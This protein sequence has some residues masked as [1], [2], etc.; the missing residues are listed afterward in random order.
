MR[1]Y[2]PSFYGDI[3]LETQEKND[4][5][6][7]V[8]TDLS[9]AEEAIVKKLLEKFIIN[10]SGV[11]ENKSF[12]LE[13]PLATAHKYLKGIMKKKGPQITAVSV[14]GTSDTNLQLKE[15]STIDEAIETGSEEAVTTSVPKRGC[16]MPVFN[17]SVERHIR[18]TAVLLRFLTDRQKSDFEREHAFVTFGGSSRDRYLVSH[19]HS[20]MASNKGIVFNLD[21]NRSV[22]VEQSILPPAEELLA[23]LATLQCREP[24][25]IEGLKE[26][27]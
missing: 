8:T 24:E 27:N 17:P 6:I 1:I 4:N 11:L 22:C 14:I 3:K 23:I 9:P 5:C 16:P 19:R 25:W 12:D 26:L 20:R 13:V 15:V 10:G 21:Q 18:A 7:M 2:F